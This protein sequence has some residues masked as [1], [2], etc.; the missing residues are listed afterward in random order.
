MK[1]FTLI[2]LIMTV[3][4]IAIVMAIAIPSYETYI[5]KKDLSVA[6][7][8]MQKVA[9]ELERWKAKN[10]SYQNFSLNHI[11]PSGSKEGTANGNVI[12]IP[13]NNPKYIVTV[14]VNDAGLGWT[15]IA[16]RADAKKGAKLKE[17]RMTSA[18]ERC[19]NNAGISA[20]SCGT[21]AE[22]W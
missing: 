10:F 11:Y 16:N 15:L 12:T 20:T 9:T 22:K 21:N 4:I 3:A 19:M 17:L 13:T 2:E 18:G 14:T 6:Q 8:E 5:R 7:Q 1:G